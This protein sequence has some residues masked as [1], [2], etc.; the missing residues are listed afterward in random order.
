MV[1]DIVFFQLQIERELWKKFRSFLKKD[2]T[3]NQAIKN[4]IIK[5]INENSVKDNNK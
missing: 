4:L 2:I 3:I 1:K 5:F